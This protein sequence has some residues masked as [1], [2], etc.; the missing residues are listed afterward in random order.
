MNR[1]IRKTLE[2]EMQAILENN[3]ASVYA[4]LDAG[5]L[6][7]ALSGIWVS[8]GLTEASLPSKVTAQ[9]LLAKSQIYAKVQAKKD[10]NKRNYLCRQIAA[11][12]KEQEAKLEAKHE[13][14]L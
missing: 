11:L 10:V 8:E 3:R 9:A 2:R 1:V 13:E 12:K 4:K 14:A 6:L 7:C 5:R